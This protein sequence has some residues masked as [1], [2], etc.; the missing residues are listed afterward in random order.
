MKL[1]AELVEAFSGIYLSPRYDEACPTPQFHRDAWKLCCSPTKNVMVIA[2]R[3]HAKSTAL[4][5]AYGMAAI[6][7][8]QS[9]YA[10]IIG[11]TEVKAQEF[12]GTISDELHNNEDLRHD[13]KIKNF[14]VDQKT[15]IIVECEDGYKF[16]IL[17]RGAE[18][19]IRGSLWDGIRPDLILCDD[20]EDDEQVESK[21]RRVK[22]RKWFFRA[23]K[24]A[25]SQKGLIRVYGTILHEDSLLSRL[26]KNKTWTHQFYKAHKSFDDF[27]ELLWPERW[28]EALL[29]ERRQEFIEEHDAAGYSQ[30]F[31]NDPF[32]NSIAYLRPEDFLPMQEEDY[33]K[34]K[35]YCVGTDFAISK[36]DSANRTS[37]TIG[38]K[39][40]D[41]LLHV[42]DE[43]VGHW[44]SLEIIEEMF[45][46]Q[47]RY[48]PEVFWV[49]DGQIWKAISSMVYKE[50]HKRD[51]WIN[52][53]AR[54][55]ISD[56]ATRG[57]SLQRRMR[58]GAVHFD[59][60]ASW[61]P[62]F[63]VELLH[64]TGRGEA[65]ADDQFDSTALLSLGFDSLAT[66]EQEDFQS[67]DEWLL[68]HSDPQ[69]GQGRN[70]ITGY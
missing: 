54:L 25:L 37:F 7:F 70:K 8:R 10:I 47:D 6:L 57:R 58:A 35:V 23:A 11:T 31:L 15:E 17:A 36:K 67:E 55:P 60:H 9:R 22:F 62:G 69:S 44:D 41:N 50:M 63:E 5:I 30:E 43:R 27:S 40:S 18:Q 13:F 45:S 20:M 38:G 51:K 12:L 52:F 65:I 33:Y 21:D 53:E 61:Y 59:K 14:I 66:V 32:D 26:R 28:T 46:I 48:N 19:R 2:P 64:F 1:T 3:D 29:R 34:P 56:K 24:Q 4:T 42:V 39:D 49:E 68:Q 16:R